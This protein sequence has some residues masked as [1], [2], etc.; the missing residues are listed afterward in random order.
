M[1]KE[2][3]DKQLLV[4]KQSVTQLVDLTYFCMRM[5]QALDNEKLPDYIFIHNI[6]KNYMGNIIYQGVD[7]TDIKAYRITADAFIL[8]LKDYFDTTA[9]IMVEENEKLKKEVH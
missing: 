5:F 3:T 2:L 9:K 1:K 6:I 4:M 8:E 7:R